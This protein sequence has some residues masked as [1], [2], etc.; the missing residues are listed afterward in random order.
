VADLVEY[1]EWD[2]EFFG[3]RVGRAAFD[4]ATPETFETIESEARELELFCLYGTLDPSLDAYVA[5]TA[6]RY[7][8]RLVDVAVT[9][10]RPAVPFEP[11]PTDAVARRGTLEDIERLDE[12]IETLEP[13]SRFGADPR[14]TREDSLRM[15]RAWVER[16][17]RDPD[18]M[19]AVVEDETGLIGVSTHV[20]SP[21]PRVDLMGV[22]KPRTGAAWALMD[23]LVDWGGGG[24]LEA[25]PCAARNVAPI[26]YLE[27]C[28][29]SATRSE[30]RFHR[31]FD[32][33]VADRR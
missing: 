24:P 9:F 17:A 18:R 26:R 15:L 29:F 3:F 1:L 6:Q 23:E 30:Y 27:H 31:W 32:E 21:I 14:F 5:Q 16:A 19:L 2:S 12:A 4:G 28:G 8:H 13:W 7:G 10:S 33:A 11:R 25:G 22:T 20:R